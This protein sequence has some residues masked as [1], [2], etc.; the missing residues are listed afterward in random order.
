MNQNSKEDTFSIFTGER[1]IP[2]I[3]TE[4]LSQEHIT[5]YLFA[6]KFVAKKQILDVGCGS[7]YG[8]DILANSGA[9][10]VIGIDISDD[11]ISYC[12]KHYARK[13]LKFEQGDCTS[14]LYKDN[15]FDVI[16]AFELIEHIDKEQKFLSEVKRLLKNNGIFI[17]STPNKNTYGLDHPLK[18]K[19]QNPFHLYHREKG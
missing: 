6:A 1:F 12:K 3:S 14:L 4:F 10:K 19:Q 11:A 8:S 15:S 17:L 16:V 7:G 13:N 9:T 5:R 2:D 18:P